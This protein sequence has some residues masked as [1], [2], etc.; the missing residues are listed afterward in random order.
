MS[1]NKKTRRLEDHCD[2]NEVHP[3]TATSNTAYEPVLIG[4]K[5]VAQILGISKP[6]VYQLAK[7]DDFPSVTI[8]AR[9]L[10]HRGWL[11]NWIYDQ[12]A[13][14]AEVEL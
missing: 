2:G 13:N 5:E 9:V 3:P 10:V 1:A 14:H 7:R 12:V 6:V 4:V 8:G 11:E